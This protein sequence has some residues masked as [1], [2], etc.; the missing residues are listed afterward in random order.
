MPSI[1]THGAFVSTLVR[2]LAVGGGSNIYDGEIDIVIH[3]NTIS[4]IVSDAVVSSTVETVELFV[5]VS[6]GE[7]STIV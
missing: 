6:E 4:A 5:V 1:L 7:T 2:G 3:A